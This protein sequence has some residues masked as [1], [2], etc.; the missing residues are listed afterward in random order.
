MTD[1]PTSG[2]ASETERQYRVVDQLLTMHSSYRDRLERRAFW[3]NTCLVSLTL[4]L[5]VFVFVGDAVLFNL[6][7][8]PEAIRFLLGIVSVSALIVSITEFRVAWGPA[9]GRHDVAT[10]TLGNLKAEYQRSITSSKGSDSDD[11][12]RLTEEFTRAM[13]TLPPIPDRW[14]IKLKAEHLFKIEI[15]KRVSEVPRAPVCFLKG[16]LRLRGI[17]SAIGGAHLSRKGRDESH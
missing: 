8:D 14:F 2:E 7:L 1:G 9:A 13:A 11:S 3:L 17:R 10:R 6:G 5:T 4:F 12:G 15:S 16:Q